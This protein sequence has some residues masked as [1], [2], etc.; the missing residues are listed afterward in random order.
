M[1]EC[2]TIFCIDRD[3][4]TIGQQ[5]EQ[6]KKQEETLAIQFRWWW[7]GDKTQ[8]LKI[9]YCTT[10]ALEVTSLDELEAQ[11]EFNLRHSFAVVGILE[12]GGEEELYDLLST[13]VQFT[14]MSSSI[15]D[16]RVSSFVIFGSWIFGVEAIRTR[17]LCW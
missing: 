4:S 2:M 17:P 8:R 7:K 15:I 9:V 16:R 14:N 3:D 5:Q 6:T 12:H 1:D 10:L 13:R 11:A